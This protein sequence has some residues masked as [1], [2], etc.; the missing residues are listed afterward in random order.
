MQ[1]PTGQEQDHVALPGQQGQIGPEVDD[2]CHHDHPAPE[3]ED[4]TKSI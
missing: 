3:Y 4:I 2:S 1:H